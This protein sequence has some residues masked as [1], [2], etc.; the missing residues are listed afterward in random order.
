VKLVFAFRLDLLFTCF[1]GTTIHATFSFPPA[2]TYGCS[3]FHT[4]EDQIPLAIAFPFLVYTISEG[5]LCTS[6]LLALDTFGIIC[7]LTPLLIRVIVDVPIGR[8][9]RK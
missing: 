5:S 1:G 8:N 9:A 2:Y 3:S 7:C 4:P 6:T